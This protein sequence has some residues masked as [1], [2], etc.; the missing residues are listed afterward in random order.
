MNV[1]RCTIKN[2]CCGVDVLH[3]SYRSIFLRNSDN[4]LISNNICSYS[5]LEGLLF[6]AGS[7]NNT[8]QNN[9]CS[10]NDYGISNTSSNNILRGNICENNTYYGVNLV[11]GT[12][13]L[14]NNDVNDKGGNTFRN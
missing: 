6:Y 4:N 2:N 14:G 1:N 10:F 12:A 3:Y 13:N 9:T 5:S 8:A 11:S 7:D